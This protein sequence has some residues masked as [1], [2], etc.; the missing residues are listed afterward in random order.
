M[1]QDLLL[2]AWPYNNDSVLTSFRWAT[3]YFPP[4]PYAGAGAGSTVVDQ[5][6]S[7][8]NGTGYELIY[9]CRGCLSWEQDG[10]EGAANTTAGRLFLGHAQ[11][12]DA[13]GNAG[14]PAEMVVGFHDNGYGQWMASLEGVAREEY[15]GWAALA[16]QTVADDCAAGTATA[17]A[18]AAAG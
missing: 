17:T 4:D 11:S 16:T 3:D 18:T 14:C 7:W 1:V 5:I 6:S 8:V 10:E 12:F 9:R 2:M 15:E 13:P